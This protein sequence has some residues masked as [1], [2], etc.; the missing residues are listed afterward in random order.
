MKSNFKYI[1]GLFLAL[2]FVAACQD[3]DKNPLNV[4]E[5]ENSQA[6]YVR[7]VIDESIVA[8]GD[9]AN[10]SFVG[11]VS[12][13]SDNVASWDLSVT[14]ESGGT[15]TDTIPLVTVDEFPS[16]I[17]IPYTDIASALGITVDDISGGDFIRFIGSATGD[18]GSVVGLENFSAT[19][20]GQPEQLQAFNFIV[21]VK[22]SPM[23]GTI[24]GTWI[25]EMQD[26]YGDGWD[27]AFVTFEIDGVATNYTFAAG[28]AATFEVDVPEGTGSLVIS[29]TS[30]AFEEEHVYTI[31]TPDGV[32]L[33]EFGPNPSPCIN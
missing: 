26:L 8:K 18:D 28:S 27:G 15:S 19:V 30:G 12:A 16:T 11:T 6:P 31:E 33:G 24:P 2:L 23:T 22:C 10:S 21:L 13:P 7:I 25:I 14:L 9:L 4:F 29:Y 32:V 3:D 17:S 1:F 5:L 20:T